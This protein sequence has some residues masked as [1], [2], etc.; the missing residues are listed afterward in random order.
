M[1]PSQ[2]HLLVAVR[3]DHAKPAPADVVNT[4][5]VINTQTSTVT[6]LV[7]GADFYSSPT[8]SPDGKHLA[9][10]QWH[11]P[12]MPWEGSELL[13]ASVE[14]AS[15]QSGLK[16]SNAKVIA[17][18]RDKISA[19]EPLWVDNETLI[20]QS[21]TAGYYNPQ[22]YS[23]SSNKS[24]PILSNPSADEYSEPAW[25]FGWS[26]T[27][28]L[29]NTTILA[30]P[31]RKGFS[32][33]IL[34]DITNGSIKELDNPFVTIN[35]LRRVNSSSAVFAGVKNDDAVALVKVEID[36]SG[37]AKYSVLK[38]TSNLASTLP[39][40]F[41]SESVPHTLKNGNLHVIVTPPKNAEYS[42]PDGEKPP[43]VVN[44]H[45]GPTGRVAPGLSWMTQYFTS[46]G[47]A[48]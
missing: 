5:V 36:D 4:L 47:W 25:M 14:T 3:E 35:I 39:P 41:I 27:A 48:W 28:I 8:F 1:H 45:G 38:S 26:R 13:V 15:D 46:R 9:W 7:G 20:Y 10:L 17:G 30:S 32:K 29:T 2:S 31:I 34:I 19:N 12:D 43:A 18:Q 21:D 22:K 23:V 24:S 16:I 37:A 42:A 11:H 33:L 44:I 6:E 40:G